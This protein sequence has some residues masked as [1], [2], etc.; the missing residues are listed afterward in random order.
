MT[1]NRDYYEILGVSKSASD[2]E[3]K[4]AYRKK[5]LEWHPD[6]NKSP[7]AEKKFKEINEAYE[8]LKDLKKKQAYDQFGHGAFT[9]G[10]QPP[11]GGFAGF[12]FGGF[13][14]QGGTRTYR[15][16]PFTF[17]YTTYGNGQ[18]SPFEGF[19]F[20]DPF[21]IFE[22]FFGMAS[23]FGKTARMPHA[24]VDIDFMEAFRGTEKEVSIGGKKRKV[25]IP[26]GV[27]DGSRIRFS[28]FFVTIN[29]RPHEVFQRQG[30]DIYVDVQIPLM[31][32]VCGGTL[33]I[34]TLE[35]DKNIRIKPGT[36]PGAVIRLSG[37]GFPRARGRGRGDFYIR[38]HIDIPAYK[39]LNLEQKK[40]FEE[41]QKRR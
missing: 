22:Q 10:G 8:V 4:S 21:E 20:S 19:D 29:V 25:K 28:D 15:Q 12:P 34:P 6:K 17:T 9:P 14:G 32:A 38:L 27:D 1:T 5:A 11:P 40:A 18:G 33:E 30:D 36:Q 41:L 26:P 2:K 13:G 23:P 39:D 35:G 37:Q 31:D 16:G 7:E 24:S 3:I